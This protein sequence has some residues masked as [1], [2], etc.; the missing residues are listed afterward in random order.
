MS[1]TW[2]ELGKIEELSSV[3]VSSLARCFGAGGFLKTFRDA[4]G[5]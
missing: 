4:A 3:V 1:F 2:Y 5:A